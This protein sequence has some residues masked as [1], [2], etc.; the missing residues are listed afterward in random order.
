MFLPHFWWDSV[1]F[2][3]LFDSYIC[4][5]GCIICWCE[6][7]NSVHSMFTQQLMLPLWSGRLLQLWL[8]PLGAEATAKVLLLLFQWANDPFLG[9]Q[10]KLQ[11][12]LLGRT[13]GECILSSERTSRN[14]LLTEFLAL[15]MKIYPHRRNSWCQY[16]VN[17]HGTLAVETEIC[18]FTVIFKVIFFH[19]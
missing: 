12:T 7:S 4:I 14:H 17:R 6:S 15:N 19:T 10:R 3:D 5:Y 8:S 9:T 18:A 16:P 13:D 2:D 1:Y 11:S